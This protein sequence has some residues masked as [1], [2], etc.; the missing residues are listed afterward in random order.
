MTSSILL[1]F[2]LEFSVVISLDYGDY[3]AWTSNNTYWHQIIDDWY[4]SPETGT[5]VGQI[6]L[7]Q[8]LQMQ[9]DFVYGGKNTPD[10]F[11]NVFRIGYPG[12]KTCNEAG[13]RYPSM[14][15]HSTYD[16]F[17]VSISDNVSCWDNSSPWIDIN[18]NV[19]YHMNIT[20]NQTWRYASL[21]K[22]NNEETLEFINEAR[23]NPTSDDVLYTDMDIW[24]S[25]AQVYAAEN[26]K[27]SGI[28]IDT[29]DPITDNSPGGKGSKG[30]HNHDHSSHSH[31]HSH[32]HYHY[33]SE[34]ES[35]KHK[36]S[37]SDSSD[38]HNYDW[39]RKDE[40]GITVGCTNPDG[41]GGNKAFGQNEIVDK[42]VDVGNIYIS[43]VHNGPT[44]IGIMIVFIGAFGCMFLIV[45]VVVC[46]MCPK[47]SHTS[48]HSKVKSEDCETDDEIELDGVVNETETVE[49]I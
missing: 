45:I 32:N 34:S 39:R 14:W 38:S 19:K 49:M 27:L 1:V 22:Y 4:I 28:M 6:N 16:K 2:V 7:H 26:V 24:F 33:Y 30:I 48:T 3:D 20:F 37:S 46:S 31:S 11:E 8:T 25:S 10:V 43:H 35:E 47:R 15:I 21:Y 44:P 17:Q 40:T 18:R 5:S 29:W 23:E 12:E 36:W 9:F 13:T 42:V 41:C